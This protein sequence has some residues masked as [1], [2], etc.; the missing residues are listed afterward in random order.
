MKALQDEQRVLFG[1]AG[2]YLYGAPID[3]TG[4]PDEIEKRMAE[5]GALAAILAMRGQH[6]G[7]LQQGAR[8]SLRDQRGRADLRPRPTAHVAAQ[9]RAQRDAGARALP[10]ARCSARSRSA[11]STTRGKSQ[12][13][14]GARPSRT[15][16]RA[17]AP[18]RIFGVYRVPDRISAPLTPHS[19]K[20]RIVEWD[21]VHSDPEAD[22]PAPLQAT[23]FAAERAVGR[24]ARR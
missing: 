20:G 23:S 13:D 9:Q 12:L 18:D 21:I 24:A 5:Q 1:P 2:R 6:K 14:R 11:A 4:S 22:V 19:E 10:R 15:R 16:A 17:S 8:Q 3:P 7:E